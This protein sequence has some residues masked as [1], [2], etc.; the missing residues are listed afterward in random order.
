MTGSEHQD[1]IQN[2]PLFGSSRTVHGGGFFC[3]QFVQIKF[4]WN[5]PDRWKCAL[6]RD[7]TTLLIDFFI[8]V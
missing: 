4:E 2:D 1:F 5:I 6:H 7:L 3:F 8:L